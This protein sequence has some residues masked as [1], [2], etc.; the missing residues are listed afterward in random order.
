MM[1]IPFLNLIFNA[2][3]IVATIEGYVPFSIKHMDAWFAGIFNNHI[4]N[5]INSSSTIEA[6]KSKALLFICV[7]TICVFFIKNI[8]RYSAMH[9]LAPMRTGIASNIRQ[10]LYDKILHLHV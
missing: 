4:V 2:D 9:F 6:G 5:Y 1:I 8:F 3:E 10:Q 7:F